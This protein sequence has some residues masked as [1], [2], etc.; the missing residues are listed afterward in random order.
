[1]VPEGLRWRHLQLPLHE[2][3]PVYSCRLTDLRAWAVAAREAA[4]ATRDSFA[5]DNG[6]SSEDLQVVLLDVLSQNFFSIY[7]AWPPDCTAHAIRSAVLCA[8]FARMMACINRLDL[9]KGCGRRR[10]AARRTRPSRFTFRWL[11]HAFFVSLGLSQNQSQIRLRALG[12]QA[13]IHS[14]EKQ[15]A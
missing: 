6:P 5:A 12:P 9:R 11:P 15:P 2:R 4:V 13:P 14:P 10:S 8:V 3:P 1:M 7:Q